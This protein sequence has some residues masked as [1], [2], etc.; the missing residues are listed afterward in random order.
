VTTTIG[1]ARDDVGPGAASRAGSA[2]FR[3]E[4]FIAL[5]PQAQMSTAAGR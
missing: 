5:R 4:W 3:D 2:L 1:H